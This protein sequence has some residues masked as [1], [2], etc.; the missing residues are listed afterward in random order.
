[1]KNVT[2]SAREIE[3]D[4]TRGLGRNN[5]RHGCAGDQQAAGRRREI[6]QGPAPIDN[7]PLDIDPDMIAAAAIGIHRRRC[8]LREQ[9]PG[10]SGTMHPSKKTR[11][12]VA[13]AI[14]HEVQYLLRQSFQIQRIRGKGALKAGFQRVRRR[15]PDPAI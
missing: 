13:D 14:R 15:R 3:R 12:R 11:M 7:L 1:M 2:L 9:I 10:R 8:D 5:R 6:E 4:I